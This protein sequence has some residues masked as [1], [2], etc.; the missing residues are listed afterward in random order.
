MRLCFSAVAKEVDMNMD[1][2]ARQYLPALELSYC[3]CPRNSPHFCIACLVDAI[4]QVFFLLGIRKCRFLV[5]DLT[6]VA[7]WPWVSHSKTGRRTL[8]FQNPQEIRVS[9]SLL[10]MYFQIET[11]L[12]H[13]RCTKMS[14]Q[15][16]IFFPK[17]VTLI[18]LSKSTFKN[19][20]LHFSFPAL[21]IVI[22]STCLRVQ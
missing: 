3:A 9:P 5:P 20:F 14:S 1:K 4:T 10:H 6:L 12:S 16:L 15:V 21:L 8:D 18:L 19:S 11:I 22:L 17:M 2:N 13:K 7:T